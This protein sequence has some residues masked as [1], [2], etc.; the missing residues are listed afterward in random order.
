MIEKGFYK[1]GQ[2]G[3][4]YVVAHFYN[5]T[6]KEF[7]S[8]CVR[9]Y[10]YSDCS[11]D[12]DELYYMPIN[13]QVKTIYLHDNGCILVGDMAKVVKGRTIEHGYIGKVVKKKEYTD[14]YG[15]WI[16]DYIYFEDGKKINI[17]NCILV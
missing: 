7:I 13:E 17:A 12:D 8:K 6:T 5:P 10:D 3:G 15:R 16:A 9:D 4:T 1:I 14:R 2:D 11:R